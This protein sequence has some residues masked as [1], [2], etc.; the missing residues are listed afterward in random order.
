MSQGILNKSMAISNLPLM[1]VQRSG[2][3]D[4]SEDQCSGVGIG[5]QLS[6]KPISTIV[7]PLARPMNTVQVLLIDGG[8]ALSISESVK[9][10]NF[11]ITRKPTLSEGL[12][13]LRGSGF[14]LILLD[15]ALPDASVA[16]SV[17]QTIG[18]APDSPLIALANEGEK[19]KLAEAMRLGAKDFVLNGCRCDSLIRTMRFVLDRKKLVADWGDRQQQMKKDRDELVA[20]LSH[21]VRNALACIHQFGNILIDGLAGKMSEEQRDYLGIMLENASRI[22]SVLDDLLEPA[23]GGTGEG[24]KETGS[25]SKMAHL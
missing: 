2:S 20:H 23:S 13:A 25:L 18:T 24:A 15:L 11:K 3:Q 22:R 12:E 5:T 19:E 9:T 16:E 1:P 21:E 7:V 8:K 14:Q 6:K 10:S 4:A 17:T